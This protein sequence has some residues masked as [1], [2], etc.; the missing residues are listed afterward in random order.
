MDETT[1]PPAPNAP[2]GSAR[3]VQVDRSVFMAARLREALA[4]VVSLRALVANLQK[5]N[6]D[7]KAQQTQSQVD[8]LDKE[9]DVGPGS[10][11]QQRTDG[12]CWRLPPR[13]RNPGQ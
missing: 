3:P 5:E 11:L 4:E 7:L 13:S 1:T 8:A 12:T 10:V 6:F 2:S 9:F